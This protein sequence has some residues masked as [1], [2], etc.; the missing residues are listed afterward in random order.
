MI[1]IEAIYTENLIKLNK[2]LEKYKTQFITFEGLIEL[3]TLYEEAILEV[4]YLYPEKYVT[5][6]MRIIF[7]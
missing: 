3:Y 2:E 4:T 5:P 1:K 7:L 6:F